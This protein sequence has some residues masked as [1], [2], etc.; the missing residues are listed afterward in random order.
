MEAREKEDELHLVLREISTVMTARGAALTLHPDDGERPRVVYADEKASLTRDLIEKV[1]GEHIDWR[2]ADRPDA[3]RWVQCSVDEPCQDVM[4]IPVQTVPGHSRLLISVYFDNL[5]SAK[6][7][8]AEAIYARRAPFAIGYFR[9]WQLNRSRKREVLALKTALN[10]TEMAIMLIDRT[11]R[12]TFANSAAQEM[13]EVGDGLRMHKGTIRAAFLRDSVRL[14]L[15]IEHIIAASV[16]EAGST[17]DIRATLLSVERHNAAPLIVAVL[18]TEERATEPQDTAAII[19]ALDPARN[20]EE[21]LK[22]VCKIYSLSPVEARLTCLLVG[23]MSLTDASKKMH[24]KEMTARSYLKQI[25][26]K[27]N[28][29][30]QGELM[31]LMLSSVIRTIPRVIAEP[32]EAM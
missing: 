17:R 18:P 24:V 2:H 22:P 15:A 20:I 7:E 29:H 14:Q 8:E 4:L 10:M 21:M 28:T 23:G 11:S 1:L 9:L 5:T 32:L 16:T 12:L 30:R 13:L 19:Y 27:T 3:H 25:F 31:Q 26:V 6:R